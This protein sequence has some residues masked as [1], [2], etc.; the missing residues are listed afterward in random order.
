[1]QRFEIL[2][3]VKDVTLALSSEI[4][5]VGDVLPIVTSAIDSI[6]RIDVASDAKHLK[7]LLTESMTLHV[8]MLLGIEENYH[9][10]V[11]TKLVLRYLLNTL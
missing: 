2:E 1:M 10:T 9:S 8:K 5:W 3:P 11:V 4:S 7:E 6:R